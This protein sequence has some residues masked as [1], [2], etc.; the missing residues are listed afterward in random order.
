MGNYDVRSGDVGLSPEAAVSLRLEVPVR[1]RSRTLAQGPVEAGIDK[2]RVYCRIHNIHNLYGGTGV[3]LLRSEM[4]AE[5]LSGSGDSSLD[6]FV[7][8]CMRNV[9]E[10]GG[11]KKPNE[12]ILATSNDNVIAQL[13]VFLGGG[14]SV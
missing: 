10:L 2:G 3:P 5:E 11:I 1:Y 7:R 14:R 9:A 8:R 6:L 4:G 12:H 13:K